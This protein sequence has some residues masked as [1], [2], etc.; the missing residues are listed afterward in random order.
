MYTPLRYPGGKSKTYKLV[1]Y[2][3]EENNCT[4]YAEPYAGGA[5][6]AIKLLLDGKVDKIYLNDYDKAIYCFWK[7]VVEYPDDLINL[8]KNIEVNIDVWETMKKIQNE[9]DIIDINNKKDVIKLGLSTFY[10]NRTNRSGI[11]KAGVIGGKSQKGNYLMD[12]RFNKVELI[13]RIKQISKY[14]SKIKLYNKDAEDFIKMNLSKTKRC[15]IFIDPP[16]INKGHQLYTNFYRKYDHI[17]LSETIKSYLYDKNWILTYDVNSL[18]DD[19]YSDFHSDN[20]YLNYSVSKPKKG[21]ETIIFS[22]HIQKRD[23]RM[24]LKICEE[25]NI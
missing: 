15:L 10:L 13:K 3:I 19:L 14:S 25:L 8:I 4:S 5:G 6:V 21:V 11:I 20:Y 2:L 22:N 18:L 17:Q 1:N 7:S 12:C 16:Y 24:Y 23:Y 9:K